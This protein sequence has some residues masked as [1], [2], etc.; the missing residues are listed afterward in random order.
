MLKFTSGKTGN[1][2]VKVMLEAFALVPGAAQCMHGKPSPMAID[3]K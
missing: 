1:E 3:A 2:D